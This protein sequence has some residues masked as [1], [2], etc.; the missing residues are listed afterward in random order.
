MN[1]IRIDKLNK[2]ILYNPIKIVM[3]YF[4]GLFILYI[5][6]PLEWKTQNSFLL[7]LFLFAAFG[8]IY[9]G[10]NVT[11]RKIIKKSNNENIEEK[12]IVGHSTI[13]KF[14]KVFITINLLLTTLFLIRTT[15]LTSFSLNQI[16]SNLMNGL[17]DAGSQ[18]N[19]KFENSGLFGGNLLA[20]IFTLLS[21]L[22][23]PVI[24]LS[25][26]Y[27]KQLNFFNKILAVITIFIEAI[28]W[29]STGTNKGIIDLVLIIVAI[30]FLKQWQKSHETS[31]VR[32][33]GKKVR[34]TFITIILII[35]GLSLFQ[36]NISSRINDDYNIVSYITNNTEV[37]VNSPIMMLVP[38]SIQPLIVYSTL[39][40]TQGFY[41]LSLTLDE[42]F[43]PMFGVGNSYFLI[44]NFSDLFNIDLWKYSYQSRVAYEGWQP[45]LNWHSIFSWLANDISYFGVLFLMYFLGKYFAV[46]YYRSVVNK[47]PIASTIFCL[48]V[49]CF[50]Y[51]S[52]NNQVLSSPSTFM[53]FY[54]LNLLW[55]YKKTTKY[56][57]RE[58]VIYRENIKSISRRNDN[59]SNS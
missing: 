25:I 26:I 13:I 47:D 10:Y 18:Y 53:A 38:Q 40:L 2:K 34:V 9:M 29:I 11:M 20:P 28:R 6:G 1:K 24:P 12:L 55:F 54:A 48:L 46:V 50:F 30:V 23:W 31:V 57:R 52:S 15:G 42:P 41:G 37:N 35:I 22:L 8:L 45:L 5:W 4:I 58:L 49:I 32:K 44:E 7:Y 56:K 51:F 27:F 3:F 14:L 19:S 16:M 33:I 21:P 43:I 36:N 39:Y 59:E 17:T